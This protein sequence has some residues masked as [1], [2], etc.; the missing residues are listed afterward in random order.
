AAQLE[1]VSWDEYLQFSGSGSRL[2]GRS[3]AAGNE[4]AG[5]DSAAKLKSAGGS[6]AGNMTLLVG[7]SVQEG[8]EKPESAAGV[9]GAGVAGIRPDESAGAAVSSLTVESIA[10]QKAAAEKVPDLAEDVR[11][12]LAK[13]FQRATE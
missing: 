5:P 6:F 3:V 9:P 12:R 7:R 10:A 4:S 1:Q 11:V 2:R 8:K 13:H